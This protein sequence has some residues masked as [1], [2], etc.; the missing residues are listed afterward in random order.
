MTKKL[1]PPPRPL[2]RPDLS[3]RPHHLVVQ[4]RMAASPEAIYRAWTEEFDRWFAD[5]GL[6]RMTAEVDAPYVFYV[7]HEGT[8]APHHG[9]FLAL[10]PNELVELTWITGR[11]GTEGAET[12]VT[13]ELERAEDHGT[14]LRL[15]HAG[16]YDEAGVARHDD[17]WA[18][19]VLP[20]LDAVLTEILPS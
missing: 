8:V 9:R 13:V 10:V 14:D 12:V 5:P 1:A 6:I 3:E 17:A 2:P 15:T 4:R 20:H 18:S 7:R 19:Y 11:L 16:F